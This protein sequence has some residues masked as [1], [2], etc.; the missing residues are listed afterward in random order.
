MN[1]GGV[2]RN[3][4]RLRVFKVQQETGQG[5]RRD[6]I[7]TSEVE[8]VPRGV[9]LDTGLQN[10]DCFFGLSCVICPDERQVPSWRL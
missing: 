4:L 7:S 9:G 6:P 1:L 8:S 5:I 2:S 10:S 3:L